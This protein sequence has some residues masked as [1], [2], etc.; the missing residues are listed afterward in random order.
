MRTIRI[1]TSTTEI[2]EV[3]YLVLG[4]AGFNRFSLDFSHV[5]EPDRRTTPTF[6]LSSAAL[7]EVLEG[8]P[9]Q[10]NRNEDSISFTPHEKELV[11]ECGYQ[12]KTNV[13]RVWMAEL[14]MGWN[15]LTGSFGKVPAKD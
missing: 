15:V 11:I 8:K 10:V 12:G 1:H 5:S 14:A 6:A 9:L 7:Y 4:L 3:P 2:G 13:Y